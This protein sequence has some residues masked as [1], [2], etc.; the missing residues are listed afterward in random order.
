MLFVL[1]H[2]AFEQYAKNLSL[3]QKN[4]W[5]KI[6]G[7][8][9]SFSFL[10]AT[11]QTLRVVAA[12][13]DNRALSTEQRRQIETETQTIVQTLMSQDA[14]P[15][16]LQFSAEKLF[17]Q[18]YPLHPLS[19]LILPVL[20][21]KIAQNER[22]LFSYLGSGEAHGFKYSLQKLK[23]FGDWIY[24]HELFDYFIQNSPVATSDHLTYRRWLEVITA[25]ERLGDAPENQVQLLKS[26]G[27]FNIIGAQGGLKAS[28]ELVQLC[29]PKPENADAVLEHLEK[30][31]VLKYQKFSLEYRV[32]QGSDFDLETV[33]IETQQQ[34]RFVS[35]ADI[36]NQ[37]K[38][39]SPV[40][41]RKYSIQYATLRY[42]QPIFSDSF[43]EKKTCPRKTWRRLFFI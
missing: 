39:L 2:Q 37:R 8:F 40:V 17:S 22:T 14:L 34:A 16:G 42:F 13:F 20:C 19:L 21:Q 36:L 11:E 10:E 23:H 5:A 9:E 1:M 31:S 38:S 24:P 4:E 28:S 35:L 27:L 32:W 3:Q 15:F 43:S 7:R 30:K 6:Q 26:I 25:L 33:L 18:C 29:L 12:A 41:A